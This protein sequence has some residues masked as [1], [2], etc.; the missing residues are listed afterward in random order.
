MYYREK[1]QN[2]TML[3]KKKCMRRYVSVTC[4]AAFGK[5]H[6]PPDE[7]LKL[8]ISRTRLRN[9]EASEYIRYDSGKSAK[10]SNRECSSYVIRESPADIHKLQNMHGI[11]RKKDWSFLG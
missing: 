5:E 8:I 6:L 10:Y 4:P 1:N 2:D 9:I 7:I 3:P 11:F